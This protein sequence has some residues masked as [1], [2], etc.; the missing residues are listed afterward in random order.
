M[1]FVVLIPAQF[2]GCNSVEALI[3]NL[4]IL[5]VLRAVLLVFPALK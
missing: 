5:A 4:I 3:P 2:R 1:L